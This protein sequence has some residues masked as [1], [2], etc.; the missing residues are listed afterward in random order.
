MRPTL[1]HLNPRTPTITG[2]LLASDRDIV[3][4]IGARGAVIATLK[5]DNASALTGVNAA[6]GIGALHAHDISLFSVLPAMGVFD[7]YFA[8]RFAL[9]S[10]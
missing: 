10:I 8:G 3:A 9:R 1:G 5:T 2:K 4:N 7:F 6:G